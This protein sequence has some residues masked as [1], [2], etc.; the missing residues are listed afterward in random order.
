MTKEEKAK[1]YDKAI[2]IAKDKYVRFKGMLSGDILED[3]F[4]ELKESKNEKIRKGIIK[5]IKDLSTDWLELH[6]ITKGDALSWLE[7][8]SEQKPATWSGE[9]TETI[10]RVISIVKWAAYSDH[11]HPILNDKGAIELVEQLKS[12][13]ERYIWKPSDEQIEA[14]NEVIRNS[15]LS[16]VEYNELVALREQLKAL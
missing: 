5:S 12:L 7:K 10:S 1:A 13:K 4:P 16:T 3:V 11:S 2:E 9:N 15:Y 14:L 8:Q 6:G